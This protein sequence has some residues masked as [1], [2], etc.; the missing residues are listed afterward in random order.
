VSRQEVGVNRKGGKRRA[1]LARLD[2]EFRKVIGTVARTGAQ[3]AQ[4]AELPSAVDR[5]RVEGPV[6]EPGIISGVWR[7]KP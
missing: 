1:S 6:T 3:P 5:Q 4:I 2:A 7:V